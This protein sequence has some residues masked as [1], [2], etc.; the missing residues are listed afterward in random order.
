MP[1]TQT[2]SDPSIDREFDNVYNKLDKIIISPNAPRSP[3]ENDLWIDPVG[4]TIKVF[5]KGQFVSL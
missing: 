3:K 5:Y 1:K 4:A 2:H